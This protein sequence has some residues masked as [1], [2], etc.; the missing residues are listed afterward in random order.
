MR[1]QVTAAFIQDMCVMILQW[2]HDFGI[3]HLESGQKSKVSS[4]VKSQIDEK[5]Q[6]GRGG[7]LEVDDQLQ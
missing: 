1:Q 3:S 6:R 2:L 7:L 4:P 5:T